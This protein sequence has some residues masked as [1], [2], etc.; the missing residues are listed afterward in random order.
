VDMLYRA[1]R[2]DDTQTCRLLLDHGA[3]ATDGVVRQ[4]T[5]RNSDPECVRLILEHGGN[6]N[7]SCSG[8]AAIHWACWANTRA[9][10]FLLAAG[11]EPKARATG[12]NG[13]TPLHFAVAN[14]GTAAPLLDAGADTALGNDNGDTALDL[15]SRD[16]YA[17]SG[18]L[19]LQRLPT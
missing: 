3:V 19:L 6:P 13:D 7:A 1:A 15:A 10:R 12:R 18:A 14:A 11:A 16:G 8:M 2:A 17:E 9:V 4:A 5:W